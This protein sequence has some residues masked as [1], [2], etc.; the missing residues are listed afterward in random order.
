M[1]SVFV[2]W[3]ASLCDSVRENLGTLAETTLARNL[4]SCLLC[5]FLCVC[6]C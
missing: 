3:G 6:A 1:V 5:V 2:L 4:D